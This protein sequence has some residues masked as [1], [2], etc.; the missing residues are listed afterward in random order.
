MLRLSPLALLVAC[1]SDL[2]PVDMSE[3][4]SLNSSG[5]VIEG[6]FVISHDLTSQEMETLGIEQ[7]DWN[8][9]IDVGLYQALDTVSLSELKRALSQRSRGEDFVEANRPVETASINDPYRDYQWNFD[10]LDIETAWQYSTGSGVTVA[11]LDTG[12][13]FSGEDAP[14]KF[15][16]G[17]DF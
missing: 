6:E 1:V 4:L 16:K 7:L 10:L 17:W 3:R 5:A 9:A 13:D 11:V 14:V 8:G 15:L 2:Q 12:V